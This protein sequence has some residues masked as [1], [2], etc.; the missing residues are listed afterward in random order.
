MKE[1]Y[2]TL[3]ER[4]NIYIYRNQLI[5]RNMHVNINFKNVPCRKKIP[6]KM[7]IFFK[8][9]TKYQVFF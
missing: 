9:T 3:N 7:Y 4:I 6:N 1:A 2:M 5:Q 8:L